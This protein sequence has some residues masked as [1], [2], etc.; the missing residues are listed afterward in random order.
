MPLIS[1]VN[2]GKVATGYMDYLGNKGCVDVCMRVCV[3][4]CVYVCVCMC[5]CV[6]LCV[7]MSMHVRVDTLVC[8]GWFM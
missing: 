2:K 3:Y 6:S 7:C 4:K 5:A 8:S 1:A